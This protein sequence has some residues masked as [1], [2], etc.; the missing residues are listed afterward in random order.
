MEQLIEANVDQ[1]QDVPVFVFQGFPDQQSG[2]MLQ[3]QLPTRDAEAKF[4]DQS[5]F[6]AGNISQARFKKKGEGL[7]TRQP[8]QQLCG[9]GPRVAPASRPGASGLFSQAAPRP[10][11]GH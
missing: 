7:A 9:G 6:P 10:A 1:G 8:K 3:P 11:C 2:D 4:F 5:D